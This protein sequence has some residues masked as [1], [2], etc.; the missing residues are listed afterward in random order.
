MKFNIGDEIEYQTSKILNITDSVK[1]VTVIGTVCDPNDLEFL[2]KNK[3][4]DYWKHRIMV[5]EAIFVL[6]EKTNDVYFTNL[7]SHFDP[8]TLIGDCYFCKLVKKAPA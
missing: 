5:G 4:P 7:V 3:L 2:P 1:Y 6:F 8:Y